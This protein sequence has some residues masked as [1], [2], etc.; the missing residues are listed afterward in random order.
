M[1]PRA[2]ASELI[3]E[4]FMDDPFYLWIASDEAARRTLL[5]TISGLAVDA[6]LAQG[7]L[8][9]DER[10]LIVLLPPGR[11]LYSS[12]VSAKENDLISSAFEQPRALLD[13]Y[14][15]RI[16]VAYPQDAQAWY[17]RYLVVSAARRSQGLGGAMMADIL[18][19]VGEAPLLLH[20][21]RPENVGFYE[22]YGM[23][24]VATTSCE[25]QGPHIYT[26][27]KSSGAAGK[28]GVRSLP[29]SAPAVR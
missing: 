26:L 9:L 7:F 18:A 1:T 19:R 21:G 14:R 24:V 13:D 22:K 5:T 16:R 25:A 4:G 28:A 10:G 29:L 6:A 12:E 23:K 11:A 17:L 2:E 27:R 20:T 8:T 3:V 15:R